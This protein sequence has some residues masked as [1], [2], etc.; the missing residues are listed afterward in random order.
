[1]LSF[2]QTYGLFPCEVFVALWRAIYNESPD[3]LALLRL[4]VETAPVESN[5]ANLLY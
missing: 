1:M 2:V 3:L 5:P 4:P